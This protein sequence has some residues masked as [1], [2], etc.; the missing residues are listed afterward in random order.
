MDTQ[1]WTRFRQ[2]S[3]IHLGI[4]NLIRLLLRTHYSALGYRQPSRAVWPI[5]VLSPKRDINPVIRS[6]RRRAN[7]TGSSPVGRTNDSNM[8]VTDVISMSNG[9]PIYAVGLE[10][11]PTGKL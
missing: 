11:Y 7:N 4:Q 8:L 9:C 5:P 10:P 1:A 3:N 6:P 2:A